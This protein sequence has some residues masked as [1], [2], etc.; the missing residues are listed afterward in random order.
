MMAQIPGHEPGSESQI[1]LTDFPI[2][3]IKVT[4]AAY[5]NS[6][7]SADRLGYALLWLAP[8]APVNW[9]FVGAGFAD[10]GTI[11]GS[12]V[13]D[14]A[15]SSMISWDVSVAGGNTGTFPGFTY[16]NA[17]STFFLQ[18]L[19]NPEDTFLFTQNASTRVL[20]VTPVSALTDLGGA[21]ALH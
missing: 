1:G 12:F 18:N 13:W 16:S 14:A 9:T 19:G 15:L 3:D 11:T 2:D 4:C 10:G 6:P 8:A 7:G 17:T 20:R 5:W 21:V